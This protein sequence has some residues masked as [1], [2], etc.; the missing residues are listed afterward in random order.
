MADPTFNAYYDAIWNAL[1]ADTDLQAFITN[2]DEGWVKDGP[3]SLNVF[4]SIGLEMLD[5]GMGRETLGG[6]AGHDRLEI[7]YRITMV[8]KDMNNED[9]RT[10]LNTFMSHVK[11]VVKFNDFGV[12]WFPVA[13]ETAS[14]RVTG[15]QFLWGA[16]IM[17]FATARVT[18]V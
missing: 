14:G 8:T 12:F 7:T 4:P 5:W 10:T 15:S 11:E 2:T 16:E 3:V 18:R 13:V 9:A 1:Y 17:L 6:S